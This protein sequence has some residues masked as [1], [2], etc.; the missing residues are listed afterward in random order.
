MD[1]R[2]AL[3]LS[4]YAGRIIGSGSQLFLHQPPVTLSTTHARTSLRFGHGLRSTEIL[5]I[6][7]LSM[8]R[9]TVTESQLPI[10]SE[11]GGRCRS[12]TTAIGCDRNSMIT[13]PSRNTER[14]AGLPSSTEMTRT[15]VS[16]VMW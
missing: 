1:H 6:T 4:K 14:V 10:R 13:S 9:I 2:L 3:H 11:V 16:F 8:R 5:S 12:S 7:T 15:V